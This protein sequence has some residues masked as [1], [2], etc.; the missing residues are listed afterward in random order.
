MT[1]PLKAISIMQPWAWLIVTG[2]K[3]VE[4]RNWR[5]KFK[6]RVLVH[7]GLRVDREAMADLLAGRHPVTGERLE[8][9]GPPQ[10]DRGGIVGEVE[11]SDCVSDS[12]SDWFV[13]RYGFLLRDAKPLPFQPCKGMLSFFSPDL[14]DA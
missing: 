4:N 9:A 13:G 10:F 8:F 5:T 11:I 12:D 6:G 7:A 14:A 3:D 2:L 1:E